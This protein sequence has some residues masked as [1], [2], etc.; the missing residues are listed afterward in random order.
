M[1]GELERTYIYPTPAQAK[2]AWER[3]A[4]ACR[5]VSINRFLLD[6]TRDDSPHLVNVM[7]EEEERDQFE[8]ACKILASEGTVRAPDAYVIEL[9]RQK[10][11]RHLATVQDGRK[12]VTRTESGMVLSEG[13]IQWPRRRGQG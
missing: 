3:A 11:T 8:R 1:I 12:R 7:T 5:N 10:R 9:L 6:H 2:R 13:G 4:K